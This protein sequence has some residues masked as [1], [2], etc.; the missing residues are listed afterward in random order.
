M[1]TLSST[2]RTSARH[3]RFILVWAVAFTGFTACT[4]AAPEEA[5]LFMQVE[6]AGET[7][8]VFISGNGNDS[9]VWLDITPPI[10]ALGVRTAVYDRAGLGQSALRAGAYKVEN[11]AE[12]LMKTLHANDIDGPVVLVAHSYGGLIAS[13]MADGNTN[14]KGMVFVDALL[15]D[16]LS[17]GVVAGVLAEYSPQ[18]AGL[19]AA[20]PA[21]AKAVIPVVKAYPDTAHTMQKVTIP[22]D[23][24]FID[25]IP[26]TTWATRPE[27][28]AHQLKTHQDFVAKS[29]ART[30]VFAAGSSHHVM[31][32]KPVLVVDAIKDMLYSVLPR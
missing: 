18:F 16:D 6:G 8:V 2:F 3:L 10:R 19:E 13:L 30:S 21:L 4:H 28:V 26:E 32:D 23:M 14:V 7:T 5:P 29:D 27:D 22:E 31:R 24:P 1:M 15:P 17:D 25:I 9:S 20:A 11:E 12:D